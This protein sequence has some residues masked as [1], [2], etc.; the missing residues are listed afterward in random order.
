MPKSIAPRRPPGWLAAAFLVVSLT[1]CHKLQGLAGMGADHAGMPAATA[2]DS[3]AKTKHLPNFGSSRKDG[4]LPGDG[5]TAEPGEHPEASVTR[6]AKRAAATFYH[7]GDETTAP[8]RHRGRSG[9]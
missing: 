5:P 2:A 4:S 6:H 8:S 7:W 3:S 9:L 1:G